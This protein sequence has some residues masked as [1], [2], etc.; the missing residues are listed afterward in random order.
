MAHAK[1]SRLEFCRIPRSFAFY[2]FEVRDTRRR[3]IGD[4]VKLRVLRDSVVAVSGFNLIDLARKVP[5]NYNR[6]IV[7]HN[8]EFRIHALRS[9]NWKLIQDE[10]KD[11]PTF[12]LYDL[13]ADPMESRNVLA[14]QPS[15]TVELKRRLTGILRSPNSNQVDWTVDD[16]SAEQIEKL[17]SLGYFN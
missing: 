7:S 1:R 16:L 11:P 4:S 2:S 17:R 14:T 3:K 8:F 9:A 6:S 15:V 5:E 10:K 13:S 12:E